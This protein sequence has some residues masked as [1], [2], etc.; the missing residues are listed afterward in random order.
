MVMFIAKGREVVAKE[1]T[2]GQMTLEIKGS[3]MARANNGI[4][5]AIM[6]FGKK[7]VGLRKSIGEK[8]V[9]QREFSA[10]TRKVSPQASIFKFSSWAQQAYYKC[11]F[12]LR[13]GPASAHRPL[14]IP[15]LP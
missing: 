3:W 14:H 13:E 5:W 15:M 7:W 1:A 10:S 9:A 8:Q 12:F 4:K 6:L 2:R 11:F